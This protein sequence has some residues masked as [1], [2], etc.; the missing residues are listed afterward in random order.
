MEG[1]KPW[2]SSHEADFFD[3]GIQKLLPQY[4]RC[5]SSGLSMYIFFVYNNF[6]FLFA[7]IVNSSLDVTF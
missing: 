3:T 1:V 6:F 2:R 4:D 7:C 5:L